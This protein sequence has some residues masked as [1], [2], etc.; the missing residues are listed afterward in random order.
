M[1]VTARKY[2]PGF[3]SDDEMVASFCVRTNEF[4]SIVEMLRDCWGSSNP[5]QLVIGPRGFWQDKPSA[6]HSGRDTTGCCTV[7]TFFPYCLRGR[8]LRSLHCWRLLAGM[9]VPPSRPG[10]AQKRRPRSQSHLRRTAGHFRRSNSWENAALAP[11]LIFRI[12]RAS[13]SYCLSR[14]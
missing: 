7:I 12:E 3:L 1:N 4:K 11:C 2:N 13:D 6:S 5:H 9:P 8:K 14:T 10:S